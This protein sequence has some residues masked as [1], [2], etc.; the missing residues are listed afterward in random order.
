MPFEVVGWGEGKVDVFPSSDE[1]GYEESRKASD[2]SGDCRV[3]FVLVGEDE[4][5]GEKYW[6]SGHDD[7]SEDV[8]V[9]S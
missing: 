2:D 4:A 6:A 8:P 7:D 5:K 3:E 1:V 9:D